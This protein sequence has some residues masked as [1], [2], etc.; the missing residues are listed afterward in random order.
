MNNQQN[1]SDHE[2]QT[3]LDLSAALFHLATTAGSRDPSELHTHVLELAH[4]IYCTIKEKHMAA[5]ND[6]YAY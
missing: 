2:I 3:I 5:P 6:S 1:P 4:K